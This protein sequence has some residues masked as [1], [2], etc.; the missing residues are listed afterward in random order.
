MDTESRNSSFSYLWWMNVLLLMSTRVCHLAE[1]VSGQRNPV[2]SEI[3][4]NVIDGE[5]R[6][7][8]L[9]PLHCK[10]R[11]KIEGRQSYSDQPRAE[12]QNRG[13][14]LDSRGNAARD[15][16]QSALLLILSVGRFVLHPSE[17]G[18]GWDQSSRGH[19]SAP[20]MGRAQLI[21]LINTE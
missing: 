16:K 21:P 12:K 9:E 4:G 1:A 14:F 6:F 13:S 19:A 18:K 8:P 2:P 5:R 17:L 11:L 7:L 10:Y 15:N 20:R 3:R